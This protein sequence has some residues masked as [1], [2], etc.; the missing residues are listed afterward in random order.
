M[1]IRTSLE[2]RLVTLTHPVSPAV[3]QYRTVRTALE[4]LSVTAPLKTIL[5]TSSVP[6]AGKSLTAS[7]LAVS[8]AQNGQTTILL[9]ADLRR[10]SIH[11]LF[12]VLNG[13]GLTTALARGGDLESYLQPSPLKEL[14]LCTSGPL[15][16]NPA[17]ML[18]SQAFRDFLATLKEQCE[19]V[20]VDSPPVMGFADSVLLANRVDGLLYV[21]R[22][23][24]NSG[25]VDQKALDLLKPA[26]PRLLGVVVNGADPASEPYAYYS[27]GYR[28]KN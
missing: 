28:S 26:S 7:N 19:V 3:E 8:L 23:G 13:Q 16:P 24:Y 15:P 21:V 9:D 27:Y 18:S 22:S 14:M 5:V 25:K 2:P 12:G 6:G 10:P 1:A 20:V 11:R 4:F 17:E